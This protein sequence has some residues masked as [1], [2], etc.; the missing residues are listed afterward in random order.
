[1][2]S[3]SSEPELLKGV[4]D[5]PPESAI[6]EIVKA[7]LKNQLSEEAKTGFYES[8][9][10][11]KLVLQNIYKNPQEEKYRTIKLLNPKF[12]STIGKYSSGL[13]IL[14]LL[15]FQQIPDND[16]IMIYS[17]DTVDPLKE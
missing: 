9:R 3:L 6:Q 15:G 13:L 7:I 12:N 10:V 5:E 16:P 11:L 4:S 2:E 1:M 8:C 14:E 17:Y